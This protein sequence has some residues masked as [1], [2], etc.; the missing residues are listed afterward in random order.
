MQTYQCIECSIAKKLLG[1]GAILLD[2]RD[3]DSFNAAHPKEAQH[4]S[5]DNFQQILSPIAKDQPILILCYHGISSK[6]AAQFISSQGFNQVF[7]IDGGFE[8]WNQ[9]YSNDTKSSA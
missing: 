4:L 9:L 8:Q 6:S 1:D 3:Q 2:I 7:S 5:N